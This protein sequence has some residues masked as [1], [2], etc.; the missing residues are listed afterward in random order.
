MIQIILFFHDCIKK[1]EAEAL[2]VVSM[3]LCHWPVG[4]KFER[5]WQPQNADNQ[6]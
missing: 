2:A 1:S 6:D 3:T 5:V 4:A